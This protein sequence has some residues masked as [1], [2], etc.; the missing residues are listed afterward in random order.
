MINNKETEVKKVFTEE[1]IDNCVTTVLEWFEKAEEKEKE[2]FKNMK[3]EDL[4]LLHH[5][6]GMNI[7]NHFKFWEFSYTPKI[8]DD[9]DYAEDHPDAMSMKVIERVHTIIKERVNGK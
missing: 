5:T 2:Y 7:R 8:I 9:V 6:L 3:K 4:C 1:F